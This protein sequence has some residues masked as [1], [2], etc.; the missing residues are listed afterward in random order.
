MQLHYYEGQKAVKENLQKLFL[1]SMSISLDNNSRF[2]Y[3][4]VVRQYR[5]PNMTNEQAIRMLRDAY[6]HV[7]HLRADEC[8]AYAWAAALGTLHLAKEQVLAEGSK[9]ND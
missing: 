4:R 1:G 9:A 8:P 3:I 5:E 6:R 2:C 7:L